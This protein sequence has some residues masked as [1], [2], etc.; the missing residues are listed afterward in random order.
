MHSVGHELC[1]G[2]RVKAYGLLGGS[3]RP[4][5]AA[6]DHDA[7][8][9]VHEGSVI[10]AL[11]LIG[12]GQLGAVA[13]GQDHVRQGPC[14]ERVQLRGRCRRRALHGGQ[15]VHRAIADRVGG[16][17][18]HEDNAL[19][20][21]DLDV[22]QLR[23]GEVVGQVRQDLRVGDIVPINDV[24]HTLLGHGVS[25]LLDVVVSDLLCSSHA[26]RETIRGSA[27]RD[28][29]PGGHGEV[30]G[31]GVGAAGVHGRRLPQAA[32]VGHRWRQAERKKDR[33]HHDD[34]GEWV[35]AGGS[36]R[37]GRF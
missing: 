13:V 4:I 26:K 2:V 12:D 15:D 30:R 5:R 31:G 6:E 32:R 17:V 33:A 18:P 29:D 20:R 3:A 27:I 25:V 28:E 19:R 23:A 37:V 35:G 22:R 11:A 7:A 10:F 24:Q 14:R 36:G 16:P 21:A 34:E 9:R 1:V 8:L